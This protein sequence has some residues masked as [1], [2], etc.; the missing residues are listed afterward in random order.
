[1][2]LKKLVFK[3]GVDRENTRYT[4]EGG[5]YDCDKVRFRAGMPEK[6]G[7][8]QPVSGNTFLGLARSL[9]GWVNLGGTKL[10]GVGTNLKYYIER[11]GEYFDITPERT[12]S[13]VSLTDPFTTVSGSTT[14]TVTDANGGYVN[15]DFVT[16]SGASAA[17]GLTL[18]GEFQITYLT[19][20]TYTIESSSAASSS[21]TGGG[22]V[23]AK[24]QINVGLE[25]AQ[26]L[27][28]WGAGTWGE[29]TWSV[30]GTSTDAFR[31]YSEGN[32]G[33]DLVFGPHGGS[34]YYWDNTNGLTTRAVA[35]SAISGASNAPT[36][37]N[38]VLVSDV[39]RFVFCL[40]ANPL[41]SATQDPMLIRWSDQESHIN[42]TPSATN[43]AGDL[44]LSRGSEIISG[45]QA[46]QEV[47]IWTDSALY[48]LQYVGAPIVW[49]STL[50]ADNVSI[51]SRK[52]AVYANGV[53]YWM[54]EGKFYKY[55]GRVQTLNCSLKKYIFND[56]NKDQQLQTFAGLN[57]GFDEVWWFYCSGSSS[58]IDKYVIYNY[59]QDIW[60]FGSL[61]RT[62]WV[63]SPIRDF[64]MAA[65]YSNNVVTHENGL[66]DNLTGASSA[67][68]A[69]ISSAQFDLDDGHKFAFVY[70]VVP[71]VSFDGSITDSPSVTMSL[72]PLQSS[73]S[74]YNSP[75]SEGGSNT[76]SITRTA[77]SP[78][79]V[80]TD[81]IYTRVRGRQMAFE[82]RSTAEDVA[83]QL[84]SPRIDMRPDGRR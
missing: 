1:M 46:R 42:W 52:A 38:F 31:S 29:S 36:L 58:T 62:A 74:G 4:S 21:A 26:P 44:R 22:S 32:F 76:A 77:S 34:V 6:I 79:E 65:T 35:L 50:L 7:G 23:T 18:N 57:E 71:D 25:I 20:N 63:D 83:W 66:N 61:A 80:F 27:V 12:P 41:G 54:G 39:N 48:S 2:T 78:V 10:L 24:Y 3:P 75:L 9:F 45:I 13:G 40:G 69:F 15:G 51:I 82:I 11:G 14:V 19:G 16:F 55:D 5:W 8:W 81:Q 33:E 28:G 59:A 53:T 68:E 73:G 56:L 64:P 17:G 67:M 49:G 37:Q 72:L 30:G 47:L 84:G 70:R 60:Y 43:Q